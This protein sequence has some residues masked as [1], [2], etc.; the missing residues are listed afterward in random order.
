M[1][2]T[3]NTEPLIS[4]RDAIHSLTDLLRARARSAVEEMRG[5]PDYW[6][7]EATDE[8]FTRGVENAVSDMYL[9]SSFTPGVA[10]TL[11]DLLDML[12]DAGGRDL[13]NDQEKI[14]H[15]ARE[16]VV[17]YPGLD[18]V[19]PWPISMRP[20]PDE[21]SEFGAKITGWVGNPDNLTEW[22]RMGNGDWAS[23]TGLKRVYEDIIV[24]WIAP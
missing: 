20:R 8:A 15:I 6:G 17:R 5:H 14:H 23:K 19:G 18:G 21:P 4:A 16:L 13:C 24:T 7:S 3:L 10:N 1:P 11:A 22:V 9:A 12:A 2:D